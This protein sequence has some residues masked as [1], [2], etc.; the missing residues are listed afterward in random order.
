MRTL[1]D[2]LLWLGLCAS[3][4]PALSCAEPIVNKVVVSSENR[5]LWN[6]AEIDR[7]T[8]IRYIQW[9]SV[10]NPIPQLFVDYQSGANC[11][12]VRN[13]F[14]TVALTS[15]NR[16]FFWRESY[17]PP[18]GQGCSVPVRRETIGGSIC[19]RERVGFLIRP[20]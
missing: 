3:S 13:V 9:T 11:G 16:V 4:T 5:L 10:L 1:R 17:P 20:R 2:A 18:K 8:L 6:G 15:D 19:G 14:R 12:I 7:T